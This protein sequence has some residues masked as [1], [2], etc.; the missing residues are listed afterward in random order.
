M[1]SAHSDAATEANRLYWETEL[2]VGEIAEQLDIS[3][4]ALYD[5]IRPQPA[6][7]RCTRCG[8]ELQYTNRSTR[9]HG[10]AT[11]RSC[12]QQS[13]SGAE[14]EPWTWSPPS[15]SATA[16]QPTAA[17]GIWMLGGAA[18]AGALLAAAVTLVLTDRD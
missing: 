4:R 10:F 12:G 17:S 2:S 5:A 11:C 15:R 13:P 1:D 16:R 14:P 8:G 18:L 3:R 7:G 6:T 9:A